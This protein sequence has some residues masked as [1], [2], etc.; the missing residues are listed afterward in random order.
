MKLSRK[1]LGLVHEVLPKLYAYRERAEFEGSLSGVLS[2]LIPADCLLPLSEMMKPTVGDGRRNLSKRV[3][4]LLKLLRPHLIQ[5]Y[6]NALRV[7]SEHN[8]NSELP[9]SFGLSPREAQIAGWLA[10]GKSNPEIALILQIS[11]RTVEKHMERILQ[12]LQVENRATAAVLLAGCALAKAR[13]IRRP[14]SIQR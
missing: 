4:I 7:T 3:Q 2:R 10:Q 1:D 14:P 9:S 12:K 5:A 6:Q 8:S 11:K 13:G